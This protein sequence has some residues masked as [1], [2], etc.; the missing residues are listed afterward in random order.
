[1]TKPAA[2]L[3]L[4]A[5]ALPV[6][7]AAAVFGMVAM[8]QSAVVPIRWFPVLV[9]VALY[10]AGTIA[11]AQQDPLLRADRF[12]ATT[13]VIISIVVLGA[14]STLYLLNLQETA[15]TTRLYAWEHEHA[16]P[17]A[18]LSADH[19]YWMDGHLDEWVYVL[20]NR[21]LGFTEYNN[22]P[23]EEKG[24]LY[25]YAGLLRAAGDFNTYLLVVANCA[26]Q[27][28]SA[29]FLFRIATRFAL[30]AA[31]FAAAALL[32]VMP[33]AIYWAG[34]WIHKDNFAVLLVLLCLWSGLKAFTVPSW[35]A[36]HPAVFACALVVLGFVRSGL[37][38]PIITAGL[39]AIVLARRAIVVRAM[40]YFVTLI[41]GAVF[42]AVLVPAQAARDLQTKT[43][44]R[45]Y[46]RLTKGSSYRLDVQNIQFR[47][48]SEESLVY[49][50]S[51]GDLSLRKIHYVPIRVAMYFVA[52]FPP[53]PLRTQLDWF[54]LPATWLLVPF[55]FFFFYGCWKALRPP[56]EAVVWSL[57]F[58]VVIAVAIAFAG[59]FVHER[60]RL[61]LMPFYWLFAMFGV[62][63]ASTR[64]RAGL[65][66]ASLATFAALLA[67]YSAL[68]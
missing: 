30:P 17:L 41:L 35:S 5:Y 65:L 26:A 53:W 25:F 2:L 44:D 6:L 10:C 32:L 8:I 28:L 66:L 16:G 48:T 56:N 49:R 19:R 3:A 34:A 46:H 20:F 27:V 67:T 14:S 63:S 7:L 54:V 60:Y 68:K 64:L 45:V 59:G 57:A 36:T 58:F 4:R 21:G 47:T 55:W 62:Y 43:F 22:I 24:L 23:I 40:K 12:R 31:A 11:I 9:A 18:T 37:V 61:L 38:L 42:V 52:P 15:P 50:L 1:L 13:F 51:G 33:D 29:W 39:V